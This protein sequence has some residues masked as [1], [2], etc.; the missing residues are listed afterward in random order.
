[1]GVY[2]L[3]SQQRGKGVTEGMKVNHSPCIILLI[4]Y[5]SAPESTFSLM[6]WTSESNSL[7]DLV[8]ISVIGSSLSSSRV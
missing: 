2:A 1:M 5:L 3:T 7:S 4:I 8:F 6:A